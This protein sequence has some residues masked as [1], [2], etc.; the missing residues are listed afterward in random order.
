[1]RR[2]YFGVWRGRSGKFRAAVPASIAGRELYLGCFG[3]DVE[4][5]YAVDCACKH[6]GDSRRNLRHEA[7]GQIESAWLETIEGCVKTQLFL[8]KILPL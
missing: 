6:L 3:T 7:V 8:C 1:M 5:A 2:P 4:A